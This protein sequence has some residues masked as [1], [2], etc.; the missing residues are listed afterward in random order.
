MT[1]LRIEIAVHVDG[2]LR[3]RMSSGDPL[4]KFSGSLGR[5]ARPKTRYAVLLVRRPHGWRPT[6]SGAE[7]PR[8]RL[9]AIEKTGL[10][11][12][13]ARNLARAFNAAS[14]EGGGRLWAVVRREP[15]A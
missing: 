4:S 6:D 12:R 15:R 11:R 7:P 13:R 9:W 3:R 5:T 1:R 2:A 14:L 8:P 10:P